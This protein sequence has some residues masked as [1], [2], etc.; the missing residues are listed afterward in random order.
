VD[1]EWRRVV[2]RSVFV[3]GLVLG[4]S[5]CSDRSSSPD[6]PPAVAFSSSCS[7][8]SCTFHDESS[9]PDGSIVSRNWNFGDGSAS[10]ESAPVHVYAQPGTYS[11]TLT[12]L[13]DSGEHGSESEDVTVVTAP[14]EEMVFIGAGDIAGCSTSFKDEATAAILDHYPSATIYALGDNAYPDGSASNYTGCYQPSWGRFK[15]RIYPTPG[16]HDYHVAGA[17]D[18]FGYFGARA[19]P[20]ERGYYSFDLGSWH[21]ISLNSE[22]DAG[23][24]SAQ[25]AWLKQDLA[26]HSVTCTLAYWHRPL[27]TSGIV[28]APETAMRSLFTILFQAGAEIVLSGHNHQYERFAPQRPDGT[29]DEAAGIRYFVAGTGGAGLYDFGTTQPNSEVRYKG[30]GVLKFTLSSGRYSWEFIPISGATFTD[31]GSAQ[32]H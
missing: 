12:V 14:A 6:V 13:D 16:N 22:I 24:G 5:F 29:P 25:A 20:A 26:A 10:S 9:D 2:F 30:W 8:L 23:A 27:F 3:T 17:A 28:H 18:Y 15:D 21:I 32:C 4:L 11:V 1:L 19:G 7:A 31:S